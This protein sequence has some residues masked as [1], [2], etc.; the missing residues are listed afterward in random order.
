[1]KHLLLVLA[2]STALATP[3]L[4]A[5]DSPLPDAGFSASR[6]EDLWTKSPFAVATPEAGGVEAS[7]DYL[8]VGI[9]NA[10]GTSYASLIERQSQE[11]FLVS[12][13]KPA[14]GLTL[15]SITRGHNGSDT[16]AVF[17]KNGQTITLKLEQQ[18]VAAATPGAPPGA[19]PQQIP[20]PGSGS[21]PGSGIITPQIPMPGSGASSPEGRP[22]IIRFHRPPIHLPPPPGQTQQPVPTPAPSPVTPQ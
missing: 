4:R 10:E 18:A 5:D 12:T 9:A 15:V 17:Q 11:H 21:A 8:L 6:Y 20:M 19:M 1:M 14:R 22:P 7:P 13:D 2:A 16:L 3:L